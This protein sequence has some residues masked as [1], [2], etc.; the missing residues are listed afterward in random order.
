MTEVKKQ[1]EENVEKKTTKKVLKKSIL[2]AIQ[3]NIPKKKFK[4]ELDVYRVEQEK[5]GE[6]KQV[7]FRLKLISRVFKQ[8]A[9]K[10]NR[11]FY[12]GTQ[13][14]IASEICLFQLEK[15]IVRID[16]CLFEEEYI[17]PNWHPI[18]CINHMTLNAKSAEYGD[19]DYVFYEDME[20]FHFVSMSYMIDKNFDQIFP[21]HGM[22]FRSQIPVKYNPT[23]TDHNVSKV[24]KKFS[25]DVIDNVN[26]GMYGMTMIHHDIHNRKW[27]ESGEG[28]LAT[29]GKFE[30]NELVPLAIFN[31]FGNDKNR[32][33]Y[34]PMNGIENPG[35]YQDEFYVEQRKD[36]VI[37]QLQSEQNSMILEIDGEPEMRVGRPLDFEYISI[38]GEDKDAQELHDKLNGW[39]LVTKIRHFFDRDYYRQFVEISKD[40]YFK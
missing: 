4:F 3:N 17:F 38:K 30:H 39:F 22:K 31:G 27:R 11:K 24:H 5:Q 23:E 16:A 1:E 15:P 10:R 34:A 37:R 28:Y 32:M 29:Y 13:D 2:E 9:K 26:Q 21:T 20:G 12:V 36:L 14:A 35:V 6:H 25:F 8:N 18:G 33:V 7:M 19:P 40:T